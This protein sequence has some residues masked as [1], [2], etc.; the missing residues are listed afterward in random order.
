MTK[1]LLSRLLLLCQMLYYL[2][3]VRGLQ[4][5]TASYIYKPQLACC[6]LECQ[7]SWE[8]KAADAWWTTSVQ[9]K[10]EINQLQLPSC[11]WFCHSV[12][13]Y[14][15]PRYGILSVITHLAQILRNLHCNIRTIQTCIRT[16]TRDGAKPLKKKQLKTTRP[17]RLV[18]GDHFASTL[19]L[20]L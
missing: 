2:K 11:A 7:G 3:L 19:R 20:M 1:L 10:S 18:L 4:N 16:C 9:K 14:H 5:D 13:G 6:S 8:C 12:K 17:E 15:V